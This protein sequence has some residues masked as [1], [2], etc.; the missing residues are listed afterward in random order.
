MRGPGFSTPMSGEAE[1]PPWLEF[2]SFGDSRELRFPL[3]VMAMAIAGFTIVVEAADSVVGHLDHIVP[4]S[5]LIVFGLVLR[6]R[7]AR[8]YPEPLGA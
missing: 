4:L 5:G 6:W 2:L 8:R 1:V 7:L 3:I